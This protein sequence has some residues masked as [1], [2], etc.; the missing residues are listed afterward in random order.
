MSEFCN[1]LLIQIIKHK[2][3]E[4]IYDLIIQNDNRLLDIEIKLLK[5]EINKNI[6]LKNIYD[7]ILGK[8]YNEII[9]NYPIL[10]CRKDFNKAISE[11]NGNKASFI[12]NYPDDIYVDEFVHRERIRYIKGNVAI[13]KAND[14]IFR[15]YLIDFIN[16]R[17]NFSCAF[18][19]C[20]KLFDCEVKDYF[21]FQGYERE[22]S[23]R[24]Y[25]ILKFKHYNDDNYKNAINDIEN[26]YR[27]T[28]DLFCHEN[29]EFLFRKFSLVCDACVFN[30]KRDIKYLDNIIEHQMYFLKLH[31]APP[32]LYDILLIKVGRKEFDDCSHLI[33]TYIETYKEL[34]I[35]ANGCKITKNVANIMWQIRINCNDT[36]VNYFI[37][38]LFGNDI[39]YYFGKHLFRTQTLKINIMECSCCMEIMKKEENVIICTNCNNYIG[40]YSCLLNYLN[41]ARK[42]PLCREE[43]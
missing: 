36:E 41:D 25:F 35:F 10:K 18:E 32:C 29:D 19:A 43:C 14:S 11:F 5:S 37:D 34:K 3:Y 33:K 7:T 15:K 28:L 6:Y 23:F 39:V 16:A 13:K 30:V 2:N 38:N 27:E 24:F 22:L 1:Q 20:R 26:F 4:G 12:E 42:C 21:P 40:H 8:E 31:K 17:D 9:Q